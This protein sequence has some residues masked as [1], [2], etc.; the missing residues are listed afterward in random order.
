MVWLRL[1][2]LLGLLVKVEMVLVV[3]LVLVINMFVD[4]IRMYRGREVTEL[5]VTLLLAITNGLQTHRGTHLLATVTQLH[6]LGH[7]LFTIYHAFLAGFQIPAGVKY[8]A[9]WLFFVLFT[10]AMLVI[11]QFLG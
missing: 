2:F 10:I 5:R 1:P 6:A 8:T 3:F 4:V 11:N 7:G 9:R